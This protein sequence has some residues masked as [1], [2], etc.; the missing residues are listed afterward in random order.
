MWTN[1]GN[2]YDTAAYRTDQLGKVHLRG[3]VTKNGALPAKNDVIGTLPA[4]TG[5]RRG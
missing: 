1:Y 5:R 3:L 4:G 2:G